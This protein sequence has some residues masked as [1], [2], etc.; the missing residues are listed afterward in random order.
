MDAHD[1]LKGHGPEGEGIAL[2]QVLRGGEGEPPEVVQGAEVV[3]GDAGGIQL[4]A[5]KRGALVGVAHR[6]FQPVKLMGPQFLHRLKRR[7][8]GLFAQVRLLQSDIGQSGR[9]QAGGGGVV[10]RARAQKGPAQLRVHQERL[11]PA[12]AHDPAVGQQKG[13]PGP[14][15][16]PGRVLLHQQDG[17]PGPGE[18]LDE[19]EDFVGHQG[20]QPQGRLV[21][22]QQFGL[23]HEGPA[24]G[25]HL[26]LP[27]GQRAG[28]LLR[29]FLKPGK[30][31]EDLLQAAAKFPA[32]RVNRHGPQLQVFSDCQVPEHFPAL[33]AQGHAQGRH[34]RRGGTGDLLAVQEDAPAGGRRQAHD[35]A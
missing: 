35:G 8:K 34:G 19:V 23:G 30:A 22:Q 10:V 2:P 15:E 32:P 11:T 9:A 27:A 14:G 28:A 1:L 25:R 6:P 26:L 20:R 21:Q 5:V 7:H 12:L 31:G 17:D 16:G 18:L 13:R 4:L 3:G 29:P 33:G 24:H